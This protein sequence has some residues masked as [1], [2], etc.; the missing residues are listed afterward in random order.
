MGRKTKIIK[1][2]QLHFNSLKARLF[3]ALYISAHYKMGCIS[4]TKLSCKSL[5]RKYSSH[6]RKDNNPFDSRFMP[7][8]LSQ[9]IFK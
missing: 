1:T 7:L 3:A 2:T 4:R 6:L 5:T 8:G 9:V